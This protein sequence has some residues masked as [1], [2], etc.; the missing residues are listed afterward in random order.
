MKMFTNNI[1]KNDTK[2][3]KY[4]VLLTITYLKLLNT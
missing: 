2:L 1:Y 4:E 3:E